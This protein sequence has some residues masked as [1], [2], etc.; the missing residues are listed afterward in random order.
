MTADTDYDALVAEVREQARI[1]GPHALAGAEALIWT[2]HWLRRSDFIKAAVRQNAGG[3]RYIAWSAARNAYDSCSWHA[4]AEP[5]LAPASSS[6]MTLLDAAITA[7]E[8]RFNTSNL[9]AE[10]AKAFATIFASMVG[11]KVVDA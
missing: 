9:G 6:A 1:S 5:A 2:D 8:R 4:D 10:H 3:Q 11:L 7:G